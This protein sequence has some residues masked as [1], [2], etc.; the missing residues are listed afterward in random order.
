[1]VFTRKLKQQFGG[2]IMFTKQVNTSKWG[3]QYYKDLKKM[4]N[5][6]FKES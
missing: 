3:I 5:S 2:K 1:M 6:N 4:R